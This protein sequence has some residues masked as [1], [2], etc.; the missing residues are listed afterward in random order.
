MLAKNVE[1]NTFI[2]I[3]FFKTPAGSSWQ[4]TQRHTW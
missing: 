3:I 4:Y 1:K 2:I